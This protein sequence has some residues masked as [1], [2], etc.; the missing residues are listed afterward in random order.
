VHSSSQSYN[1]LNNQYVFLL[2]NAGGVLMERK[3]WSVLDNYRGSFFTGEWPN[4]PELF[5]ITASRFP[6]RKAFTCYDPVHLSFSYKDAYGKC[7]AVSS[8]MLEK[9]FKPGDRAV[10]SGKNSP[11]WAIAYLSVLMAGGVIVPVDYQLT[12]EEIENLI[13]RS[14]STFLF[15]DDEKY[16][17]FSEK[18]LNLVSKISLAPDKANY[19][20]EINCKEERDGGR[21]AEDDLAAILFTSGTTGNAKGVMLTH[22][23]IVSDAF[24]GQGNLSIFETDVFYAV[25]PI[26]HSYTMLAVFIESIAVGAEIVFAKKL[27]LKQMLD[28][29]KKGKV[30]MFLGIPM[31]FNRLIK[32]IN[33]GVKEKGPAV[34]AIIKFLM[35]VSGLLKKFFN[36]NIGKKVFHKILEKVSI[37]NVRICISGG[38]P[39]PQETFRQFNQ[40]GIDFVQGYG[41]T[42]TS[43]IITLNPVEH[44]KEASVGK[45]LPQTDIKIID[46]DEHGRGEIVVKGPMVMKGY[47]DMPEETKAVF[48]EDGYLKTGD[49]GYLDSENY[50]YLTGR[51]KNLIVTEGGKNVYPEE[52]EDHFQLY[53]DI[54]QVLVRGF[55]LDPKMKTESIEALIYPAAEILKEKAGRE[56]KLFD[57]G[58]MKEKIEKIVAEVNRTLKPYEKIMKV[59]VLEKPLETTTTRKIKRHK[60][61]G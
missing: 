21:A 49:V 12:K 41:L 17:Y 58:F 33:K 38:G 43:P 54:E 6:E 24:L 56:N 37:D 9:G 1:N 55:L 50:L 32:G 14:K 11:E 7:R 53:D 44:Y 48:T 46:K 25:L 35:G 40:L 13:K 31:L 60:V 4:L 10:V 20:I 27:V 15:I 29:M 19:I 51:K 52:I 26:H 45:V 22:K 42:E 3:P 16:D 34:N 36:V 8:W 28:D 61:D 39:L 30:T 47:L 18:E 59:S 5:K 23:N 2:K 57:Q